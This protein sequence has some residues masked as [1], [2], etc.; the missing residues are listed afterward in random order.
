MKVLFLTNGLG[1]GNST[2]CDAIIQQLHK[3]GA[4]VEMITSGNGMWYFSN[5]TE[6]TALHEIRSLAYGSKDGAIS[7]AR[8]LGSVAGMIGIFKS[9]ARI[10]AD[11]LEN[12]RPDIVVTD[13]DYNFL[14]VKSRKIP[15]AALNNADMVWHSY[16]RFTDRPSSIKPQFF[17]VEM[18]DY[19]FHRIVPDLVLSP[20]LDP[21]LPA[22]GG[23]ILRVGPIVRAGYDADLHTEPPCNAAVM[24]SGSAFG[25]PVNFTRSDYPVAIDVIGRDRPEGWKPSAEVTFHGKIKDTLPILGATDLAVVNGGFSAVSE[26][27][28]MRKPVVVV[29]VPNHAEQWINA[30]TIKHLGVGMIAS[31]ENYEEVMLEAVS[32]I[33]EFR[34]GYTAI[35]SMDNGAAQAAEAVLQ[36]AD[37]HHPCR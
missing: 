36:L 22:T 4:E 11:V 18:L 35:G 37:G 31:Q 7:I 3:R 26:M 33:D 27:F 19:N 6:I 28:W 32:R 1:L 23:N 5:R 2:R 20:V 21:S 34:A 16:F 17:A 8:T 24:L 10:I 15:I 25:T 14:P 29:P 30:R 12:S 9:N 13:S